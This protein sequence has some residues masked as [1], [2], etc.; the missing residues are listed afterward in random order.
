MKPWVTLCLVCLA[1]SAFASDTKTPPPTKAPPAATAK[2]PKPQEAKVLKVEEDKDDT[3]AKKQPKHKKADTK[4]VASE[5][6]PA[7]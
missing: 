2:D 7:L 1:S 3:E 6:A 4:A 5:K